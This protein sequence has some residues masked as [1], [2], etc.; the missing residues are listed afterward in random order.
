LVKL[1]ISPRVD[2]Q[3]KEGALN[4]PFDFKTSI[5]VRDTGKT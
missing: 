2:F 5:V 3:K 1:P 4:T